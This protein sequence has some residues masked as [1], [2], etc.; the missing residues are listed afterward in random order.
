MVYR[1]VYKDAADVIWVQ[2]GAGNANHR[3]HFLPLHHTDVS[4]VTV[5][6]TVESAMAG[7]ERFEE[8][9][10]SAEL[11]IQFANDRNSEWTYVVD[12]EVVLGH[13]DKMIMC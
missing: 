11:K 12:E 6:P 3:P 4:K 1:L 13:I 8:I 2:Y 9:E 7:I 10:S 5:H